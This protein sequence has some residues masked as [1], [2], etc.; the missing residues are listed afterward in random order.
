MR[1]RSGVSGEGWARQAAERG[2]ECKGGV[3]VAERDAEDGGGGVAGAIGRVTAPAT[4]R[5][6]S[7][8]RPRLE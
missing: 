2:G 4:R 6:V 1:R 3:V 8:S 7:G 5:D